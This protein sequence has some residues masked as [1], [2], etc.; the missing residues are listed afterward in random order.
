MPL[1]GGL[2]L[3]EAAR[4]NDDADDADNDDFV[5]T[6]TFVH[7]ETVRR[8]LL[9]AD[10]VVRKRAAAMGVV[11]LNMAGWVGYYMM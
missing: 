8:F 9:A 11:R 3:K 10:R 7:A 1:K 5:F 6:F 2:L 4:E